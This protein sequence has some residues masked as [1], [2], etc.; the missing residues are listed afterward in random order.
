LTISARRIGTLIWALVYGGLF[1]LAI[2]IA[3][4]RADRSYGI[5]AIVAGALAIAAGIV[6][7]W[8]RSRMPEP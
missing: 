2:G 4:D 8:V 1:V 7:L 6:L 3:L 5:V